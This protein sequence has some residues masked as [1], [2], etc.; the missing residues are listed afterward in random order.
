[1]NK[2][3]YLIFVIITIL[4]YSININKLYALNIKDNINIAT[5][6]NN[7]NYQETTDNNV[8][9]IDQKYTI[10]GVDTSNNQIS[11]AE[12]FDQE[13]INLINEVLAYPRIIVPIII[14]VL[15]SLDFFKAVT[16]GKEDEMKKA[17]KKFIKRL[18]MGIAVFLVPTFINAIM[19]LANS[20]WTYTTCSL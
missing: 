9:K 13:L 3:K 17:Q 14:V 8:V 10:D 1:M 15:G 16:A 4:F 6:Q 11:C 19:H 5:I 7:L 2:K 18:V 20:I 12:L